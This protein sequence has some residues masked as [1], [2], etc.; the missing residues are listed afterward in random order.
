MD[1]AGGRV[2]ARF[3]VL[4]EDG[5]QIRVFWTRAEAE[6]FLLPGYTIRRQEAPAK[7]SIAELLKEVGESPF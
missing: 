1:L 3:I 4:D 5:A 2:K 7:P 6:T